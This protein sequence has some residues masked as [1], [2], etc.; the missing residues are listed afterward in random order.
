V[1]LE[2]TVVRDQ[3]TWESVVAGAIAELGGEAHL[4]DI[5][6]TIEG[7]PKTATNPTWRD[8]VRRVVRQYNVFEPVPPLRSGVY[9]LRS[10]EPVSLQVVEPPQAGSVVDHGTAQGMLVTLGNIYGYSTFAP[11]TDQTT[12]RFQ[13]RPLGDIVGLRDCT[14]IFAGPNVA[15]IRQIDVLWLAEDDYGLFPVYAFEVEHTTQVRDGLDRLLKIPQRYDTRLFVVGPDE[16]TRN[17]FDRL[18]HQV[19]FRSHIERFRFNTYEQLGR[20]YN[21]AVA[22]AQNRSDFGIS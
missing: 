17:L 15:K 18:T 19:P 16:N 10:A 2:V 5:N 20:L 1:P 14:S 12:R 22:H 21:A 9:R 11:K 13:G 7:H 3:Q 8:T 6:R 4:A